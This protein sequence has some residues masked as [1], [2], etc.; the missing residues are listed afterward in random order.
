[1]KSTVAVIVP[2]VLAS[3][4]V[5]PPAALA[6]EKPSPTLVPL[7]VQLVISRQAGEKKVSSLPYTVWV[8]AN[9]RKVTSVRMG[10]QIPVTQTVFSKEGGAPATSYSY[11][12]VGTNIDIQANATE[13]GQFSLEIRLNDSS[14]GV[15]IKEPGVAAGRPTFRNFSSSFNILLRDGQTAQYA[16]ATDPVSGE[17]LKVDVTI[18]VLK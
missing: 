14:L 17:T 5:A 4:L 1:V 9:D 8:T 12:D 13:G 2:I 3:A 7:R 11:R 18:A 6:Q 16:S 10:V 15:D